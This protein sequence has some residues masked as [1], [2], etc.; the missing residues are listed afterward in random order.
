MW[1]PKCGVR[2]RMPTPEEIDWKVVSEVRASKRRTQVLKA[3]Q[4]QP[5][6]NGELADNLGLS[7]AWVRQQVKWLID[8]GLV[9][10]L[11]EDKHNYKI[12]GITDEGEKIADHL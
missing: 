10:D 7:T 1:G 9:E 8:N 6:L 12:Y 11:T 4:Q 5:M 2:N 3:L